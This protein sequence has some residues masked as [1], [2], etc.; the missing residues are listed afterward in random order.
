MINFIFGTHGSGKTTEIFKKI[1]EDTQ[2]KKRC[3]LMI[4]DQEA[5]QF[6]RRSLKELPTGAQLYLETLSF[7]RLYNRV[8][9]EYGGLSYSYITKPMRSLIM[10]KTL[11]DLRPLLRGCSA[12]ESFDIAFTDMM[13]SA[14]DEFK[15]SGIRPQMLEDAS[16]KLTH[17]TSL[18][19]KLSDISLI[20]TCFDNFVSERYSDSADDLSKLN[21]ILADHDFFEGSNVYVDAFTSFT[22]VQH[23]ILEHIFKTADNVYITVPLVSINKIGISGESIERSYRKLKASAERYSDV[24][25]IFLGEN[26]RSSSAAIS[27]LVK[28]LWQHDADHCGQAPTL[29][30]DI[31]VLH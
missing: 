27:Y 26:R 8:C 30:G 19:N 12:N 29:D 23:K 18:A 9:R 4:P 7:S 31:V 28:N 25:E 3:F 24:N 5:V 16:K 20:Y 10:W 21:D 17:D 15:H 11:R 6:E 1:S 22:A 14:I 2:N 13:L